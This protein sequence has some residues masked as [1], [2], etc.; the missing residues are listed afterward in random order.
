M[1]IHSP[2]AKEVGAH[3]APMFMTQCEHPKRSLDKVI[4]TFSAPR[5]HPALC[6]RNMMLTQLM[7]YVQGRRGV[8][9][10]SNWVTAGNGH[11]L[12]LLAGMA[13]ATAVGADY[14]FED[15]DAAWDHSCLSGFMFGRFGV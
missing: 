6:F 4:S 2:A 3:G 12:S 5:G 8:Y 13:C 15:A 11:D 1:R 14:P 9:F 7:P 10:C